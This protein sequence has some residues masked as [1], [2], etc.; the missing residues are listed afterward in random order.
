MITL[1]K[2]ASAKA[3]AYLDQRES[4]RSKVNWEA[5]GIV[6][7]SDSGMECRVDDYSETGACVAFRRPRI[8]PDQ[9]KVFI[10][11]TG[12][13]HDCQ[14]VRKDGNR[15]GVKFRNSVTL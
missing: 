5:V 15:V 3:V 13:L 12:M 9:F 4:E 6:R 14:L 2:N 10:P 11:E 8:V 1:S 7:Q